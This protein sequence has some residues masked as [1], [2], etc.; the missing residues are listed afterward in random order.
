MDES[1]QID[2]LRAFLEFFSETNPQ[3]ESFE[4]CRDSYRFG[5]VHSTSMYERFV[6]IH[7]DLLDS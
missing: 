2:T 6:R 7:E 4:Y 3:N 5:L 1:L